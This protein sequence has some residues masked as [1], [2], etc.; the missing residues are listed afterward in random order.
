MDYSD[1]DSGSI[2]GCHDE[3]SIY[4][5]RKTSRSLSS[6]PINPLFSTD[7]PNSFVL[8][9]NECFSFIPPP[10]IFVLSHPFFPLFV[11]F[12]LSLLTFSPPFSFSVGRA[13]IYLSDLPFVIFILP[14]LFFFYAS[15]SDF[16]RNISLYFQARV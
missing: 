4:E 8:H 12:L 13:F 16:L 3:R 2:V 10:F 14:P 11:S 9:L 5:E 6:A 1:D 15:I 7:V